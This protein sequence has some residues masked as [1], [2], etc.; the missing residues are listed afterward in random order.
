MRILNW[1]NYTASKFFEYR[2]IIFTQ[3]IEVRQKS[4]LPFSWTLCVR[5]V[6]SAIHNNMNQTVNDAVNKDVNSKR[7]KEH[8]TT[9]AFVKE[10]AQQT[11][12][13]NSYLFFIN[14]TIEWFQSFKLVKYF[15]YRVLQ[16]QHQKFPEVL[17]QLQWAPPHWHKKPSDKNLVQLFTTQNN[18]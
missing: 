6:Y 12:N 7:P 8:C 16:M 5:T 3:E 10:T 18:L 2:K 11:S 17:R 15:L 4:C 13:S 9:V 1:Y 14:K